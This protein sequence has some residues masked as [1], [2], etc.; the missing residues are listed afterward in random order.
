MIGGLCRSSRPPPGEA[1]A[2]AAAA[3]R[4]VRGYVG[5][6]L[7]RIARDKLRYGTVVDREV[8]GECLAG[9]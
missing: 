4:D 3:V 6:P 1:A 9:G 5:Q 8:D 2:A 7:L